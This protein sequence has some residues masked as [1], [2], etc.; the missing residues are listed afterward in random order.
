MSSYSKQ[1]NCVAKLENIIQEVTKHIFSKK[2]II[3]EK[4]GKKVF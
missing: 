2:S 1:N 4:N 3:L